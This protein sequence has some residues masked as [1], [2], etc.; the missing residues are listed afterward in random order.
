MKWFWLTLLL[1]VALGLTLV[2]YLF[3]PLAHEPVPATFSCLD[4]SD[5]SFVTLERP[6][7]AYGIGLSYAGHIHETASDFDPD[8]PPPVFSK[9][10]RG[11]ALDGAEVPIPTSDAMFA[12][13]DALQ[14]GLGPEAREKLGD[15]TP[16]L[17]Y[18]VEL[19]VV[20]LEDVDPRDL[21]RDDYAPKLGFF[22]ANDLSS[23]SVALLG[24]GQASR[25]EF[26]GASKSFPG[27]MPVGAEAF[28]PRVAGADSLPCVDIETRVNGE[29]RQRQ[30]TRD[31]I[32]TPREMLRFVHAKYPDQ[33]LQAG[34][35][36]LTGTPSGVAV[37]VPRALV[38]L[39]N[40][41]GLDRFDKLEAALDKDQSRFLEPG[42]K[43]VV[44]GKGLGEVSV[45]IGPSAAP[46]EAGATAKVGT[47]APGQGE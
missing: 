38:R 2:A 41:I 18:E 44:R 23:R 46:A 16:L 19:G 47:A 11:F 36:I 40:L 10:P 13:A 34:D 9:H 42:D 33:P 3:R 17:D 1:L 26:W 21:Q 4:L 22:I 37:R 29:V 27:F 5:G 8:S 32:Y 30:N 45:T 35:I 14:P 39:A 31:L 15:V 12:A 7:R 6:T 28:V 43:V 24:E 20:L 25:Y